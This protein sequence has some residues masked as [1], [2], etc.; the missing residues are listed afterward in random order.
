MSNRVTPHWGILGNEPFE[1]ASM[2]V[3]AVYSHYP[4]VEMG[5]MRLLGE[6]ACEYFW[7]HMVVADF[8]PWLI[9]EALLQRLIQVEEN[10]FLVLSFQGYLCDYSEDTQ[11]S[12]RCYKWMEIVSLEEN[13]DWFGF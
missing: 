8:L 4:R 12:K 13:D 6:N 7:S 11:S 3:N 2:Y 9:P 5:A 10:V 1:M